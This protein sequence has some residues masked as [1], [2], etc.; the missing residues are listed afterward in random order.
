V[1]CI[2]CDDGDY[3]NDPNNYDENGVFIPPTGGK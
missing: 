1:N 2:I 3:H